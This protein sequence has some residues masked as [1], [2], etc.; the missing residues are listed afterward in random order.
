[1]SIYTKAYLGWSGNQI[2]FN[3]YTLS[4]AF[5][6]QSRYATNFQIRNDDIPIPFESGTN[7]YQTLIG[8]CNYIIKG[9]MYPRDATT[10]YEGLAKLRSVCSV[11]LQKN[12]DNNLDNAYS[13]YVPYT[14]VE[15]GTNKL[16]YVKALYVQ[17]IEDT[18]QGYVQPFVIYCKVQ[19]PIIYSD[20]LKL[21]STQ[22]S[23]PVASTGGAAFP[24]K[25]PVV[26][27]STLYDVSSVATN[28]GTVPSYP[29]S[30]DIYG[31]ITNPK[32]TNSKTGEYITINTTLN[33]TSDR[34]HIEYNNSKL[35]V[36]LNGNNCT[37]YVTTDSTYFKIEPGS[38]IITLSGSS[39]GTGAYAVL[40]YRDAYALA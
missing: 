13:G 3:D 36:T 22:T 16:I 33:S 15:S 29:V 14:W 17:I 18:R 34:I 19:D 10:Y 37:Q 26:F 21:A 4:P 32:I 28:V 8:S 6:A 25:F 38:N 12:D 24:F 39:I 31:P 35:I 23:N 11:D 5:R 9:T 7:D 20:T 1:M 30:I 2:I 40:S 27:G